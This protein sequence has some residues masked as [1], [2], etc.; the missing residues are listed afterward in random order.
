[1]LLL[2]AL[3]AAP[4][5]AAGST[6]KVPFAG[7][8][9]TAIAGKKPAGLNGNWTIA[10]APGGR[11]GIYKS[12]RKLVT[13]SVRT[14]GARAVFVDQAGPAACP[15]EQAVGIYRWKR[16]GSRLTLTPVSET[17]R[18]RRVVLSSRPLL[19]L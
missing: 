12:G 18:G 3:L 13:G 8:Y 7:K 19:R 9:V 17:C 5:V 6:A 4:A 15:A 14:A 1:V 2:A 16:A 11:F 10:I